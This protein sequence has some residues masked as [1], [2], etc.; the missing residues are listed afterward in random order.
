MIGD[1]NCKSKQESFSNQQNNGK[2]C[3]YSDKNNR[4]YDMQCICYVQLGYNIFHSV[5]ETHI[6]PWLLQ[7]Q[8]YSE[9]YACLFLFIYVSNTEA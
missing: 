5:E 2:I 9:E 3:Y 7:K 4:Y 6:T 1:K 8:C